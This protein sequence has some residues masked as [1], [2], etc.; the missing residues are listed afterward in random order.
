MPKARLVALM[1]VEIL[2]KTSKILETF[3]VLKRLQRTA[4]IW[5]AWKPKPFAPKIKKR[6]I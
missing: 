2:F 1:V 6:A 5:K 3:E 4:G